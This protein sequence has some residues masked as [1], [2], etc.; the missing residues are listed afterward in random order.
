MAETD[1]ARTDYAPYFDRWN[2]VLHFPNPAQPS[3]HKKI[4]GHSGDAG[5]IPCYE[6][7]TCGGLVKLGAYGLG[8]YPPRICPECGVD[9]VTE[10]NSEK[11]SLMGVLG[12]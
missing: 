3:R 9:T 11:S 5:S 2:S 4:H 6:H 8:K 12:G 10:V 7:K 1:L